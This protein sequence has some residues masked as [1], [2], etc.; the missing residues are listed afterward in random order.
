MKKKVPFHFYSDLYYEN[1]YLCAGWKRS[2]VVNYFK[3]D[4][5]DNARGVTLLTSGGII[6]WVEDRKAYGVLAHESVH[7]AKFLFGMKGII[8][9]N[10]NDEPLAY[11]VQWIFESC[12]KRM[13]K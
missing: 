9:S 5:A 10:D 11:M 7:A 13:V 2:D 4:I 1:F 6:I 3:I 8:A 12:L